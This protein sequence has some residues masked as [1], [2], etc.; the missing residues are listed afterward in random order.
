MR[1]MYVT[2]GLTRVQ[3]VGKPQSMRGGQ[4]ERTASIA[5][6][7]RVEFGVIVSVVRESPVAVR[8]SRVEYRAGY[9]LFAC[10]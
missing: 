9:G 4:H 1:Y 8:Q 3:L 2:G 7:T 5:V 10:T 6:L